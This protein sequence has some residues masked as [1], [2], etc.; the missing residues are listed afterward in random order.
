MASVYVLVYEG[1]GRSRC[2]LVGIKR[3]VNNYWQ[4]TAGGVWSIIHGGGQ[5]ALPGGG[6]R[7]LVGLALE[8]RENVIAN[9][10]E[11]FEEETGVDLRTYENNHVESVHRFSERGRTRFYL[12]TIRL[13][14]SGSLNRL[15]DL[16]RL[17]LA[18]VNASV[19]VHLQVPTAVHDW[20][21]WNVFALQISGTVFPRSTDLD[22][23]VDNVN[24][25]HEGLAFGSI[26][27]FSP[28]RPNCY[29]Q[30]YHNRS[31]C[32]RCRGYAASREVYRH[33][34]TFLSHHGLLGTGTRRSA[35]WNW[36]RCRDLQGY[37]AVDWYHII[38]RHIQGQTTTN[39]T[40]TLL[41]GPRRPIVLFTRPQTYRLFIEFDEDDIRYIVHGTDRPIP[42]QMILDMQPFMLSL[43]RLFF[44]G[45]NLIMRL[46]INMQIGTA[47]Q[48]TRCSG[49][50]ADIIPNPRSP[51][52]TMGEQAL[53]A[54]NNSTAWRSLFSVIFTERHRINIRMDQL[55]LDSFQNLRSIRQ[56]VDHIRLMGRLTNTIRP[57]LLRID[58]AIVRR[59]FGFLLR[60]GTGGEFGNRILQAVT[61]G[62]RI[63]VAEENRNI[64][65]EIPQP[66]GRTPAIEGPTG[67]TDG[68]QN[69][70]GG[71]RSLMVWA[72]SI[73]GT[74]TIIVLIV[75]LIFFRPRRN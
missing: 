52:A 4:G 1:D 34:P 25:V 3:L 26:N 49:I 71:G 50:Q 75:I 20:E 38:Y 44:P 62:G 63:S 64:I 60:D 33:F 27:L 56:A 43:R 42:D 18:P 8:S 35:P 24:E 28:R 58:D 65:A 61:Q 45:T 15:R 2:Y 29:N 73:F 31:R 30:R 57:R 59:L 6:I 67:L 48:F 11:E 66:R 72:I 22:M 17:N 37:L 54:M 9:A 40:T 53:V 5:G 12:V 10:Y 19:A 68:N 23:M 16:I 13:G 32:R 7:Q 70:T 46:T 21:M 55:I 69:R 47:L 39:W 41:P 14:N 36:G 74:I 51:I